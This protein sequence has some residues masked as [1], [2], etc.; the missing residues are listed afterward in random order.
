MVFRTSVHK[1]FYLSC[2]CEHFMYHP[3]FWPEHPMA[4]CDTIGQPHREAHPVGRLRPEG[5]SGRGDARP[6]R[7]VSV[8]WTAPPSHAASGGEG[9][10]GPPFPMAGLAV[11]REDAQGNASASRQLAMLMAGV[12]RVRSLQR[13]QTAGPPTWPASSTPVIRKVDFVHW[14]R[15][16]SSAKGDGSFRIGVLLYPKY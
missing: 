1:L 11:N 6:R 9:R 7:W 12:G 4:K 10:A 5:Y 16:P 3:F 8:G 2:R 13:W 14:G 15:I